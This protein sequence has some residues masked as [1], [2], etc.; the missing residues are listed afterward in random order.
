M[1]NTYRPI[2]ECIAFVASGSDPTDGWVVHH[3]SYIA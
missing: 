3:G 2:G 1:M